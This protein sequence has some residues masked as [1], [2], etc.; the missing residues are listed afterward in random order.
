MS[1]HH[2]DP[3][4][5]TQ[6]LKEVEELRFRLEEAEQTLE[7][8]RHAEVD[9]LVVAGPQGEQIFSITGAEHIYRVIVETVNEA[10]FGRMRTI[11]FCNRSCCDLMKTRCKRR[12]AE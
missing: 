11:L 4:T 6:L 5:R 7:A 1:D 2:K 10:V 9:A 3:R 8:I 12:W